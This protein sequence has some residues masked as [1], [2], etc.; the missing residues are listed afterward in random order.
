MRSFLTTA[1]DFCRRYTVSDQAIQRVVNLGEKE[2][3][4]VDNK[5][6]AAQRHLMGTMIKAYIGDFLYGQQAFYRIFLPEDEDMK[7]VRSQLRTK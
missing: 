7:Q 5:S 4:A 6:L 1:L 3:I 2:G